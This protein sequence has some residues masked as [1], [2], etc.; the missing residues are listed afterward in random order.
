M[1]E[2]GIY[3]GRCPIPLLCR[4]YKEEG[5]VPED[6]CLLEYVCEFVFREVR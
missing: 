6:K 3:C 2:K 4:K 1:K 5:H